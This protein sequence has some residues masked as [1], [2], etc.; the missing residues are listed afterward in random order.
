MSEL[1]LLPEAAAEQPQE[2]KPTPLRVVESDR[3]IADARKIL[4]VPRSEELYM[5]LQIGIIETPLGYIVVDEEGGH[6]KFPLRATEKIRLLV[7]SRVTGKP[8][9]DA[10]V[11]IRELLRYTNKSMPAADFISNRDGMEERWQALLI[12]MKSAGI[13]DTTGDEERRRKNNENL[14]TGG[15]LAFDKKKQ[16][17]VETE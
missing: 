7:W 3:V 13:I 9:A 15:A 4:R 6:L 14:I 16:T 1:I 11:S 8:V 10:P 17:L 5:T 2:R 12:T